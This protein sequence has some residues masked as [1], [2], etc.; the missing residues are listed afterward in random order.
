MIEGYT[1][2]T[3]AK[4]LT[5]I[6]KSL[7]WIDLASNQLSEHGYILDREVVIDRVIAEIKSGGRILLFADFDC[8]GTTAGTILFEAI[9]YFGG[10][11][12]CMFASRFSGGYG[13]SDQACDRI[14][15]QKPSL[16]V[17]LDCGSS[18]GDRIQRL[19]DN[20]ID[21]CTIDH[22]LVPEKPLPAVGFLNPHRPECKSTDKHMASCGL[23]WSVVWGIKKR[24]RSDVDL[25]Q[26][27]DLVAIGT[28]ADVAHLDGDN[29]ILVKA[30]LKEL[31][32]PKRP[33]LAALYALTNFNPTAS[34]TGRDIGFRV[35]P[36]INSVGRM[37]PPDMVLDLL[38]EKDEIRAKAIAQQVVDIWQKRR[39]DTETITEDA[40]RQVDATNQWYTSAIVVGQESWNHGIVGI[41]AARLV[42]KFNVPVACIGSEG[43]G[44]LRGPAGSTLY[45]ALCYCKDSLIK[46]GGHQAAA[47]CQV[48]WSQLDAFR[49]SFSEFFQK[50]PVQAP[51]DSVS[52]YLE[53]ETEDDLLAVARDI[54][55]LE[56]CGQGNPRPVI[57]VKCQVKSAKAVKGNHLKL[58]LITANGQNLSGFF[59]NQG[60]LA[61]TLSFGQYVTVY[62][63]LKVST[64]NG[65]TRPEIFVDK[66]EI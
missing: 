51:A 64:W 24:L 31:V 15:E 11:V 46:Y 56:P 8:D 36:P 32:S 26:W 44:S 23:A 20:G 22:H 57:V 5:V 27:L 47:G 17:T 48:D 6:N 13:L 54:N 25:K 33:G 37:G 1:S 29:R 34:L 59:I 50:H 53:L 9:R 62:G 7:D 40:I 30:G 43:R 41:V 45:D 19:K 12:Q 16:V 3:L 10:R 39:E 63:D 52:N 55:R 38:T 18:D 58:D 2:R 61:D 42:E 66:V 14:I 60:D 21:T 49:T 4:W 65:K 35:A 28:V